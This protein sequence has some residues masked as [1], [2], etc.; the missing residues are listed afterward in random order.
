MIYLGSE[1][2]AQLVPVVNSAVP[3][4]ANYELV[5]QAAHLPPLG[6]KSFYIVKS[7]TGFLA[8]RQLTRVSKPKAVPTTIT[9]GVII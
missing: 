9:N 4:S 6:H 7:R 8:D 3:A 5:F 2:A 1:L